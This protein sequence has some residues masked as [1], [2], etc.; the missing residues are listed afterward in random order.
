[1]SQT[2]IPSIPL[3]TADQIPEELRPLKRWVLW[4]PTWDESKQKFRKPPHSPLTG[5]GIGAT[6]KYESHFVTFDEALV[7]AHKHGLGVGFVFVDGDGYVGIDFDDCLENGTLSKSV[8]TWP[9]RWFGNSWCEASPSGNGLHLIIKGKLRH[10]VGST[11]LSASDSAKVEIYDRDRFFT[12]SGRFFNNVP[13][14]IPDFQVSLDKLLL[15]L[16]INEATAPRNHGP[17]S[18]FATRK[19]HA[20]YLEQ[21]RDAPMGQGNALLNTVSFFA[22]RAFAAHALPGTAE[23]ITNE[24]FNIVTKEWSHPHPEHGARRTIESGWDD[25]IELPLELTPDSELEQVIGE[26]NEKYFMVRNF[27]KKCVVAWQEENPASK[28]QE[29]NF[30]QVK[31]FKTFYSNRWVTIPGDED[32]K[33]KKKTAADVW[34]GS[35]ARRSY[36][37]VTF[38]PGQRVASDTYNLWRSFAFEPKQ[39]KCSLYLKHLEENICNGKEQYE[40]A[41]N[42][43]AYA[44]QHPGEQGHSALVAQGKKGTGKNV[45]AEGFADLWGNHR[46]LYTNAEHV[47]GRFNGQLRDCSVLILDECFYAGNRQHEQ[48]LKSLITNPTIAAEKKFVDVEQVR[49][50]LHVIILSNSEW[51]VNATEDE[52][53]YTV[54]NVG[55]KHKEDKPYFLA[56]A[57]ELKNGGFAALLYELLHRNISGFTPRQ[58]LRTEGLRDQMVES[59]RGVESLWFECLSRGALPG[60]LQ[61]NG[62][63]LMSSSD[64]LTWAARQREDWK[65][66]ND[67]RLGYIL[68][69][70]NKRGMRRGMGFLKDQQ[71]TT[72]GRVRCWVIPPLDEARRIW[73]ERRFKFGWDEK[74]TEWMVLRLQT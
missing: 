7:A 49:N 31:D 5:E 60:D 1:M 51:V 15:S 73:N 41:L 50:F 63:V 40:Y 32:E 27:G 9:S 71:L 43:M 37:R 26:F 24:I 4:K 8:E 69:E 62:S 53:R 42:W 45:W 21:L 16:G 14:A 61:K 39:G 57:N 2:A 47:T 12:V 10:T 3:P 65:S 11:P 44:V 58:S 35:A 18:R 30:Q 64:L 17:L 46:A 68:S 66:I 25:G 34:V 20:E 54:F 36:E 48:T 29:V 72:V 23:T 28:R 67:I 74:E 56:I 33:E 22:G 55:D 19:I 13:P 70:N 52:R 59:L 6:K 38:A